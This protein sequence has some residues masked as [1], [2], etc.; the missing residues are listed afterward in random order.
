MDKIPPPAVPESRLRLEPEARP[1]QVLQEVQPEQVAVSAQHLVIVV[2]SSA[3]EDP[4]FSPSS[5]SCSLLLFLSLLVILLVATKLRP[6]PS[7]FT[8]EIKLE[9]RGLR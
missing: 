3:A 7:D 6:L 2:S 4:M 5:S 1:L 8:T 9:V